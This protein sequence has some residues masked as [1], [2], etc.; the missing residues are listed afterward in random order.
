MVQVTE[1]APSEGVP[2]TMVDMSAGERRVEH[3]RKIKQLEGYYSSLFKLRKKLSM[4]ISMD[5]KGIPSSETSREF[6][7]EKSI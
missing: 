4:L 5:E 6:A 1:N 7:R 2:E 3:E